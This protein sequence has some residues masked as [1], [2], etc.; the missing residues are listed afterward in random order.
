MHIY[1]P[2][3]SHVQEDAGL[4]GLPLQIALRGAP[5]TW[6]FESMDES[7]REDESRNMNVTEP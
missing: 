7:P 3:L 5:D 6:H 2:M 4:I 1:C